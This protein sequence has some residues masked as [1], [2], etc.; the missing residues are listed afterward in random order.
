MRAIIYDS[1]GLRYEPAHSAQPRPGEVPV[2]VTL[3]GICE[4]DLQLVEGYMGFA[5]VLG[6]E[7]VG[8]AESGSY[9]GQ[10]VV[11]EINCGCEDCELCRQGM[12]RHCPRRSV[13]GILNHDGA[14][15]ETVFVPEQ[16]LHP[17]PEPVPDSAA[18]FTEPLAAAFEISRQVD[19]ANFSEAV[20]IG[21]GRLA[22]LIAQVLA[23]F[24]CEI[25]V[26]GKHPDK[27]AR[28]TGLGMAIRL[29]DQPAEKMSNLVVDC[30]G[31]TSGLSTALTYLRPRGTLVLKTTTAD[32]YS[33]DLAPLVID[34]I[35]LVGSRCGPFPPALQALQQG[36]IETE[37]L[38][39][40]RFGLDQCQEAFAAAAAPHQGK[41]LFEI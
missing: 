18:V 8:I 21:D 24:D 40:A 3:A 12:Q 33:L 35:T 23:L 5:G 15:A 27:L 30:S 6:H 41:V 31:S 10:R 17:V 16:N 28:F 37:A 26:I 38:I 2:R 22:W 11:G 32:Q 1:G 39:T 13:I 4:T 20:L 36:H 14:F 7:F 9:A 34:E 25:T 19:L 29:A